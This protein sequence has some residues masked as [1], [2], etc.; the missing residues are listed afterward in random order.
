MRPRYLFLLLASSTVLSLGGAA[1][2]QSTCAPDD[3][4]CRLD[5]IEARLTE[6]ERRLTS[7]PTSESG[8]TSGVSMPSELNC[9]S[10]SLCRSLVPAICREAGFS[11]GVP[12]EYEE[13]YSGYRI[14]R[15]TCLD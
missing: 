5:R 6:I 11:R 2:A 15:V 7:L 10:L 4:A 3:T 12:A 1:T 8:G 13:S 14:T 9:S